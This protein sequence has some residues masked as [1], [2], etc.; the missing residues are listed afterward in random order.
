MTLRKIDHI[1]IVVSDIDDAR[2]RYQALGFDVVEEPVDLPDRGVR[3]QFL[4]AG[5]DHIELIQPIAEDCPLHAVIEKRGEGILHICL[6]VDDIEGELNR[7]DG[8]GVRLVDRRAWMSPHGWA[9]FIH[10]KSMRGVSVE[11][12]EKALESRPKSD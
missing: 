12:R 1:G 6:E 5:P 2:R 9:A 4:A 3:V 11:L 10:P 8:L 7:L